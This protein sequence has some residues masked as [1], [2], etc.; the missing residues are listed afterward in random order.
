MSMSAVEPIAIAGRGVGAGVRGVVL[1]GVPWSAYQSLRRAEANNHLRMTYDRGDLEIMSPL[2]KHGQI[3]T[4][5][6]RMIFEW[7]RLCGTKIESGRDMTC[8]REDLAQGLEPGL[9]Y[10]IAHQSAVHGKDEIDLCTDPPP[11][12]ALEVDVTTSSIPKLPIYEAL[13]VPEVWRWRDGLEVLRLTTQGSYETATASS[14]LPGFPFELAVE[15]IARRAV[16]DEHTLI[17][18]FSDSAATLRR[19]ESSQ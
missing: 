7:T 4:L 19:G 3:A 2:K 5:L 9:C 11:D 15:L 13:R 1:H 8:D 16:D 6:D 14:A 17:A 18:K 10:W 12:L